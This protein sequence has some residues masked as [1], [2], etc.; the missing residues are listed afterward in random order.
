MMKIKN[1]DSTIYSGV[2]Y[3]PTEIIFQFAIIDSFVSLYE[4]VK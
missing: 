3:L 2:K 4:K 1:R